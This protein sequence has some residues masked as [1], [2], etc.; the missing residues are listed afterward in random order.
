MSVL[1]NIENFIGEHITYRPESLLQ[2]D[3]A[4][5]HHA[6]QEKIEGKSVLVIGA[7]G[8]IGSS[9]V[10][11]LIRYNPRKLVVAD[12]NEN[13]LTELVRDC[14]SQKDI[15]LPADFKSYPVNFGDPVF[16]KIFLTEGPFDIVARKMFFLSRL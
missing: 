8:T 6:L 12:I 11:A 3:F 16:E 9:F 5:Y 10:K 4:T 14:R 2:K 13:G 7:A 1:F 15:S